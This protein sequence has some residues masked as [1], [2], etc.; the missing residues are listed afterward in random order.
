MKT[1]RWVVLANSVQTKIYSIQKMRPILIKTIEHPD[2]RLKSKD[3]SA[4][5]F[6]NYKTRQTGHGQFSPPSSPHE[7]EHSRFAKE[8]ADFLEQARQR[9]E[10]CDLILCAEPHF[11]GLLNKHLTTHTL[12]LVIK[13][14]GKDYIPLPKEKLEPI[15]EKII[16]EM[17]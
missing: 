7:E 9:H 6:G 16:D 11:Q 5:G 17:L 12:A 4:D 8:I 1:T 14:L 2:S 15:L 3:L 13:S 10:Y